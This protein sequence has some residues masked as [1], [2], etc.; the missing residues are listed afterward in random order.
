MQR[1]FPRLAIVNRGEPAMRLI[2]AV[3]ELNEERDEPIRARSRSTPSPS[4][5]RCSSAT[6]TRRTPRP[7]D[8]VDAR[9]QRRR[10]TSTTSALERALRDARPTRPG[11][12]WGFV[13]EQP[14]FAELC[15]RLGHRLRR[16]RRRRSCAALGDKIAAKRLAEEAG[17]PVAP[18]SGG[19]V[20]TADEALR[21]R[22][23]ASAS[24]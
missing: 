20:E 11:S 17:V 13:A 4:A 15:E 21:A 19:P 8:V 10:A 7:G 12:G 1:P 2:H 23:S 6:P 5:T 18:W 9:R 24:R 3:R 14:E 16:A 22:A